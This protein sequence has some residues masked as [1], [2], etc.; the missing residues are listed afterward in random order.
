PGLATVCDGIK[1]GIIYDVIERTHPFFSPAGFAMP[2]GFPK[3][4]RSFTT[5]KVIAARAFPP[6]DLKYRYAKLLFDP[7]ESEHGTHVAGIAAGDYGTSAPGPNGRAVQV[8]GIA[9]HAYLGNYRVLTIPTAQFGLD[10]NSPEI[11][12]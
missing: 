3:G 9:P 5:A 6:P 11:V 1:T 7:V 2:A 8:S 4:N 12:A 10:G